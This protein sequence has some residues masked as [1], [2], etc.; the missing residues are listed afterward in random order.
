MYEQERNSYH[1]TIHHVSSMT[2]Q[3][4]ISLTVLAILAARAIDTL[5]IEPATERISVS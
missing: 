2:A 1:P 5:Y 3:S 4:P